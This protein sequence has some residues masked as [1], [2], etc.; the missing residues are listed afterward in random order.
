MWPS[1][2][3]IIFCH[4]KQHH[5]ALF[6]AA[7]GFDGGAKIPSL[8]TVVLCGMLEVSSIFAYTPNL[9]HDEVPHSA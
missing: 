6:L 9:G 7:S 1:N 3:G 8:L 5:T 2:L 4:N